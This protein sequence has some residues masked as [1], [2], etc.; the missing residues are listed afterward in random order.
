[1]DYG[2]LLKRSWDIVW[3]NKFM[4]IL[5][6]LAALGSGGSNPSSRANGNFNYQFGPEDVPSEMLDQI[7][8]FWAQ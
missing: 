1:M 6:F 4:F 7:T 3:H 8:P 5:G 2:N